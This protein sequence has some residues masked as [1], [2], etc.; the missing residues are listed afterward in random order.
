MA[1]QNLTEARNLVVGLE[2][3]AIELLNRTDAEIASIKTNG[4]SLIVRWR[5]ERLKKKLE[6]EISN[7][8]KGLC[9]LELSIAKAKGFVQ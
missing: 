7:T 6:R 2:S 4:G 5:L 8:R 3:S 1:I 9:D